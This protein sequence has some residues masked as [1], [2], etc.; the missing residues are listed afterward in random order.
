G[1]LV[2]KQASQRIVRPLLELGGDA[3][4]IV[5]AD[6]DMDR[7]VEGA[8]AAKFRNNGQSCIAANRFFVEGSVFDEFTER[9]ATRIDAMKVGDPLGD[10]DPDLGPLID[11]ER[12][13]A[14]VDVVKDALGRGGE[15]AT[16]TRDDLDGAFM[17]PALV[18]GA[19]DDAR[20]GSEEVFGPAAGVFRFGDEDELV[21]RANNTEM[22]LAAYVYTSNL[23]RSIR[24]QDRI[25]SGI[26]G[27]NNA[28]PS[29]SFSPMGGVKQS[30]L[31]REGARQGLEEFTELTYVST[32]L[33]WTRPA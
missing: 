8:M 31:G 10:Q 22:G 4:F 30:G 11:A 9:L 12:R 33:G 6:A 24:M 18:V 5:F 26:L 32:E 15:L 13:D 7:A 21:E 27:L 1:R 28:L 20:I 14:V 2:M 3:P 29:V 19:P 16:R 17:A 23:E 25:Q